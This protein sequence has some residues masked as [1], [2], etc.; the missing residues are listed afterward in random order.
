[1]AKRTAAGSELP[2]SEQVARWF[3]HNLDSMETMSGAFKT[4][5]TALA[6]LQRTARQLASDKI[7]EPSIRETYAE[8]AKMAKSGLESYNQVAFTIDRLRQHLERVSKGMEDMGVE[9]RTNQEALAA[10][11]ASVGE[12]GHEPEDRPPQGHPGRRGADPPR[13][14]RQPEAGAGPHPRLG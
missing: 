6:D 9:S 11:L 14:R 1:M 8:V 2:S 5:R 3:A 13:R 10:C 7:L 12:G 4:A